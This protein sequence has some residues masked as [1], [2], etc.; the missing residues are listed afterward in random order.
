MGGDGVDGVCFE[1]AAKRQSTEKKKKKMWLRYPSAN[2]SPVPLLKG[3]GQR[4]FGWVVHFAFFFIADTHASKHTRHNGT[5]TMGHQRHYSS[6]TGMPRK[7]WSRHL[8]L[9]QAT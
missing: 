9:N 6:S 8:I 4:T 1:F 7:T 5:C 3:T 2:N